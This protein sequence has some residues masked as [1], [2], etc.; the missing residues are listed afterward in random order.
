M[1]AVEMLNCLLAGKK[2]RAKD[3]DVGRF[4]YIKNNQ[5]F[6]NSDEPTNFTIC[7]NSEYEEYVK[8]LSIEEFI[9][10]FEFTYYKNYRYKVVYCYNN[11]ILG[12]PTIYTSDYRT[13]YK[14][15]FSSWKND[16]QL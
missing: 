15:E 4:R 5:I 1:N 7:F 6:D 14:K 2:I 9:V 13:F 11:V 10:G 12:K 8:P 16:I 3:W